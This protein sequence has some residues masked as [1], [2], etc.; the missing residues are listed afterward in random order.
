MNHCCQLGIFLRQQWFKSLV[1]VI[2]QC[3]NQW[4][5]KHQ[6]IL[7]TL[8]QII[9]LLFENANG[10]KE[11]SQTNSF[12]TL[13]NIQ[14]TTHWPH[15]LNVLRYECFLESLQ[16]FYV[17][18]ITELV[19]IG[20]WFSGRQQAFDFW[21]CINNRVPSR[22]PGVGRRVPSVL[23][24]FCAASVD[25]FCLFQIAVSL[26]KVCTDAFF[27][28]APSNLVESTA[29]TKLSAWQAHFQWGGSLYNTWSSSI[30]ATF[31]GFRT[32][33]STWYSMSSSSLVNSG[34][35]SSPKWQCM[36]NVEFFDRLIGWQEQHK[37]CS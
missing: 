11:V 9:H 33:S 2:F 30:F 15:N 29:A 1:D 35:S 27:N 16:S 3:D 23:L 5:A 25:L 20:L 8:L 6:P 10:W 32:S 17:Q 37:T 13:Q 34:A 22:V 12:V 18:I 28:V 4:S 19:K 31:W 14:R 21:H 36:C 7:L 24:I 26:A